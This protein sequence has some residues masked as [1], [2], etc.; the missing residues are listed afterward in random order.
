MIYLFVGVYGY[1]LE[2]KA[3]IN[4]LFLILCISMSIWSFAY[5][6][7]YVTLEQQYI[8]MKISAI[9]WCSFSSFIL[10]LV[11]LF[12]ENKLAKSKA[13]TVI[14]YIPSVLFFYMSV[15][16]F[17]N[18][19]GP[20]KWITDFFYIG[21]FIYNF[22]FLLTS[23]VLVGIWGI[24]AEN[25]RRKKQAKIIIITSLSPFVLNLII[26]TI[27][28]AF[29]I[30]ILPLLGH[31]YT[32]VMVTGTFY[33]MIKYRLFEIS[34][35]QLVED[36]LQEMMDMVILVSVDG[37]IKRINSSTEKLLGYS[38]KELDG[39]PLSK[40]IPDNVVSA[41]LNNR[42]KTEIN[43]FDEVDCVKNDG[44]NIPVKLSCSPIIDPSMK[45]L[46]GYIIVAQ[47]ITLYKQ[48]EKEM[49]ENKKAQ[50]HILHL[51]YHDS[52]TGLPNRK[53]FYEFVKHAISNSQSEK[54]T[55]AIL[56]LDMDG[57][58]QINDCYGHHVG[59]RA[60][61]E[62]GRRAKA[63]I[64]ESDIV[65]RIGGDEFTLV[66]M[67]ISDHD[68]AQIVADRILHAVNQPMEITEGL[69]DINVSIGISVYPIDGE[70]ADLLI[71]KADNKMY[72]IKNKKKNCA[73]EELPPANMG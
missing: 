62:V 16:L 65:A 59:D 29:G 31:V 73:I 63:S 6:F 56:Y 40:I 43:R 64:S 4:R 30:V 5:A 15:F 69:I 27:L 2:P 20:S 60:L 57:F 68:S 33:A 19:L 50:K 66:I 21:N 51:A 38:M 14:L 54:D 35:R 67:G 32:L 71:K 8:W 37:R 39:Q 9:G 72:R 7:V 24:K 52:L 18:G 36:L 47:D 34:P 70:N 13:I 46:L 45:D 10:H 23:I 12:T 41:V 25:M 49:D 17:Y 1:N 58:K 11:L 44:S 3:K 42:K 28:P 48:L 53:H 61:C 55:F 26:E 22:S